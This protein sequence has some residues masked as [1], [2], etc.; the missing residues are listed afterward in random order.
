QGLEGEL[1]LSFVDGPP[2]HALGVRTVRPRAADERYV[3]LARSD[4]APVARADWADFP[5]LARAV[6][7]GVD[8]HEGSFFGRAGPWLNTAL[9]TV[10]VW[11]SVTGTLAW[12]RR[13]PAGRVGVPARAAG[14]VPAWV[15]VVLAGLCAA[16]P[17]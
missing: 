7:T 17:L 9:A 5:P 10:L 8:L 6:A 16:L 14:P 2:G 12:W 4:G 15:G 11:V 3:Q 13:R 1:R